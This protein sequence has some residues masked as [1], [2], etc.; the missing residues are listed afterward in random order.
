M[1]VGMR[2]GYTGLLLDQGAG[3]YAHRWPPLFMTGRWRFR[4]DVTPA[5]GRSFA[6]TVIDSAA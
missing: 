2:M 6:V 1:M 4:F 5:T 3:R